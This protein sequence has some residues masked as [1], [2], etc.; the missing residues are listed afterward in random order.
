MSKTGV[1]DDETAVST[2]SGSTD[3]EKAAKK[4]KVGSNRTNSSLT[5]Q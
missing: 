2:N 1:E 3:D 4:A 5:R